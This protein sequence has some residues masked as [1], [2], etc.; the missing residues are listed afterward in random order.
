MNATH[1]VWLVIAASAALCPYGAALAGTRIVYP[2]GNWPDDVN[3]VQAAVSS[4]GSVLLRAMNRAGR[5]TAF[6]FG[7]PDQ[8]GLRQVLVEA[9]VEI[10]GE[11]IRGARTTIQGGFHPFRGATPVSRRISG[12]DFVGAQ[13]AAIDIL[14][15]AGRLEISGNRISGVVSNLLE[16]PNFTE[17]QGIFISGEDSGQ[18]SGDLLIRNNRVDMSDSTAQFRFG[19]QVSAVNADVDISGN[20]VFIAQSAIDGRFVDSVGIATLRCQAQVGI[21]FNSVHIGAHE[22]FVGIDALGD[23]EAT[24]RIA[25]NVVTNESPSADAISL[26]GDVQIS[27][28]FIRGVVENNVISMHNSGAGISL[29]ANASGIT[30]RDNF[31]VGTGLFGIAVSN[32]DP[33]DVEANNRLIDNDLQFF[34]GDVGSIFLDVNS[35]NTLVKGRCGAVVDLGTGNQVRCLT[36]N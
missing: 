36:G 29:L 16:V 1:A 12:I 5:P 22:A 28:G 18:I 33:Q 2:T 32:F 15:S 6:N 7:A 30:V 10:Q 3:N 11:T 17:A 9:N 25:G 34:A 4:D 23:S 31:I 35:R 20:E 8:A 27:S 14:A 21:T 24:Y 13:D 26:D 19:V